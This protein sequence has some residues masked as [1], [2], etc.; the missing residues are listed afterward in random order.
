MYFVK[1]SVFFSFLHLS[2]EW[3][4]QLLYT[5]HIII[6]ISLILNCVHRR[7]EV[8]GAWDAI[9]LNYFHSMIYILQ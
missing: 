8:P 1:V 5:E 3:V 6:N 7:K 9:T 2:G 4:N